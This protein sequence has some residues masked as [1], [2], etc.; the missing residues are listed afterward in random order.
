LLTLINDVLD[1]SKIEAGR[2]TLEQIDVE[3]PLLI[4]E[5]ATLFARAARRKRV[6]VASLID[7]GVPR[8]VRGDPTRLRQVLANLIGNA[9]KF[10][11]A[12]EVSIEARVRDGVSGSRIEIAVRDSG[13]GMAPEALTRIFESFTQADSSTTRRYGGT[14]LGLA[15]TRRLIEAMSG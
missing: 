1:F 6:E 12:G 7:P 14:G 9:V 8:I 13:I 4:E 15:I 11:E 3:L 10:T 5:T 2:L